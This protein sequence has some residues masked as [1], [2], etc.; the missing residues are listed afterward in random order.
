MDYSL[1][2]PLGSVSFGQVSF[3]LLREAY[4]LG[5]NPA[6]FPIGQGVDI[7]AQ[8]EDIEF[9]KW[10]QS[11]INKAPR[12]HKRS[13]PV[14]KLWHLN[15]SLE[16]I[17]NKQVLMSFMETDFATPEELNVVS[18]NNKV[19][20]TNNYTTNV[21]KEYGCENVLNVPLGFDS[22]NFQTTNKQYFTDGRISFNC[23]GKFEKRKGHQK[24]IQSWL[25]KYGN[26]PKY[27]LNCAVHN[28][29]IHPDQMKSIYSQL[30]GGKHY[31]NIQFLPFMAQNTTYCDY[32]CSSDIAIGM[33]GAEGFDLGFF[34]SLALG[35][36]GVALNAHAYKD[37]CNHDNCTLI[38][39][40]G[41][42]SCFDGAFFQPGQW[43]QGNFYSWS[44]E[45][46]ID[47]CEKAIKRVESNRVNAAGLEL[48]EKF[49]Y[50]DTFD[51]IYKLLQE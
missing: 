16:S 13:F 6:I 34:H 39:P 9:N 32:L 23:F 51:K 45:S 24:I 43:N 33:S 28:P 36:H 10:L 35:K 2:L 46:F 50:K 30:L 7:S 41:K 4:K 22:W 31:G 25:S 8:K 38:N 14:F 37:Y 29:F 44:A 40:N 42:E 5:H 26:N 17:S 21:F 48:Q 27:F 15:Q 47:G 12:T 1:N 49:T 18:Q 11:N 19:L 3:A 20:F